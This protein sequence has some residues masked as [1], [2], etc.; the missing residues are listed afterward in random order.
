[1][2]STHPLER[3]CILH[4]STLWSEFLLLPQPALLLA[5]CSVCSPPAHLAT[6]TQQ[7]SAIIKVQNLAEAMLMCMLKSHFLFA[8]GL[9]LKLSRLRHSATGE[10]HSAGF[11]VGESV[12]IVRALA[13]QE[14]RSSW[15]ELARQQTPSQVS[16]PRRARLALGY[17]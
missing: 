4:V 5:A 6:S 9:P 12:V 8:F 3:I 13:G 10:R 15:H 7:L 16:Q 17:R 14:S 1:M 11:V 2:R